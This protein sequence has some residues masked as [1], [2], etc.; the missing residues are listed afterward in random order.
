MGPDGLHPRILK[1]LASTIAPILQ[2]IFQKSLNTGKVPSDWKQANVSPIFKKGER[3]NAANYRLVS[4]TCICIK[5]L[6]HIVTKHLISYLDENKILYD[7]QHFFRSKRSTELVAFTQDILNNLKS[8]KQTCYNYGLCQGVWQSVTLEIGHQTQELRSDRTG[9]QLDSRFPPS[10][11]AACC[12]QRGS[13]RVGSS[14]Q[15]SASRL[16]HRPHSVFSVHKWSPKRS[17]CYSPTLCWW[18]HNVHGNV[19]SRWLHFSLT[20]PWSISSMGGEVEDGILPP[21]VQHSPDY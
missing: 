20:G 5:L 4:L 7:L 21:K 18:H 3:Y 17:Q 15:R 8:G 10:A 16:G 6:E 2:T 1:Q 13:F 12:V 19:W 11:V 14:T 9:P